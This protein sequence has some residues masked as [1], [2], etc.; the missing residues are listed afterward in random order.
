M[1]SR[2]QLNN[3]VAALTLLGS[4]CSSGNPGSRKESSGGSTSGTPSQG[5]TTDK[6][7]SGETTSPGGQTATSSSTSSLGGQTATGGSTSAGRSGT[8]DSTKISGGQTAL[9]GTSDTGLSGG[10][11]TA[12]GSTGDQAGSSGISATGGTADHSTRSNGG[13]A[14]GRTGVIGPGGGGSPGGST[15]SSGRAGASGS[16]GATASTGADAG[17]ER[18]VCE[19]FPDEAGTEVEIV[20][21]NQRSGP[22]YIGS[23]Q[24]LCNVKNQFSVVDA[25]ANVLKIETDSCFTCGDL[26]TKGACVYSCGR[27]P[28]NRVLPGASFTLRWSGTTFQTQSI[29]VACRSSWPET[30]PQEKAVP[31]GTYVVHVV[32]SSAVGCY[33]TELGDCKCVENDNCQYGGLPM[34]AYAYGAGESYDASAEIQVPNQTRAVVTFKE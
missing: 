24:S 31:S 1:I 34:Y 17:S 11:T 33:A 27:S 32:A 25:A 29:A 19:E 5:G 20:V 26:A 30:C 16:A 6:A 18:P 10:S 7:S 12:G 13:S 14:A 9:G 2:R 4:A 3:W 23:R 28:L 8:A 22:I 21:T 15:G